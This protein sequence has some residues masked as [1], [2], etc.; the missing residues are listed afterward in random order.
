MTFYSCS[1]V[2]IS[3]SKE[4]TTDRNSLLRHLV[5]LLG[6]ISHPSICIQ[7]EMTVLTEAASKQHF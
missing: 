7:I 1:R 3:F 4:T 2:S 6:V 5:M